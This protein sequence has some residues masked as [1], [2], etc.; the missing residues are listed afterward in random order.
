MKYLK[1]AIFIASL[2]FLTYILKANIDGIINSDI[3]NRDLLWVE[4]GIVS[5]VYAISIYFVAFGWRYILEILSKNSLPN[6]LTWVWL[7]SNLYKYLPGNIF[8]YV[9]RQIVAKKLGISHVVLI[10]S[11]IIEALVIVLTSA[12][13]SGVLLLSFDSSSLR[14]LS[15]FLDVKYVVLF[16]VATIGVLFYFYRYK[17]IKILAFWK[18]SLMYVLFFVG[19][20]L[21]AY[22]IL[23]IQMHK[24]VSF[25]LIS[26]IYALAWLV[27]FITPGA[28]GGIGVRESVFIIFSNGLL[29]ESDAVLLSAL[30]RVVS[31]IGEA[32]LFVMASAILG[33]NN[34]VKEKQA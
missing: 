5:L 14:Y 24:E 29:S 20:G 21:I 22:Y 6:S 27:G 2:L 28:P 31:L 15:V 19:I 25:F 23:N 3:F 32:M 33:K 12:L 34:L 10:Q 17:K 8:N 18:V 7:Q 1:L 13:F 30:L 26:A 9:S 11:N 4:I 16:L